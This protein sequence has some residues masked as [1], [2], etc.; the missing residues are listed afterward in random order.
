MEFPV[1]VIRK[2]GFF[3]INP[4]IC[5]QLQKYFNR[6]YLVHRKILFSENPVPGN[7]ICRPKSLKIHYV[8]YSKKLFSTD[9]NFSQ[10][11]CCFDPDGEIYAHTVSTPC[12]RLMFREVSLFD[13]YF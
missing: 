1:S 11:N 2:P 9:L 3:Y 13:W 10:D 7:F 12:R 5:P 6:Y 4:D 8:S